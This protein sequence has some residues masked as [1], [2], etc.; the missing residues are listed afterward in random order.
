VGG[1]NLDRAMEV[2]PLFLEPEY[3]FEWGG[4]YHLPVGTYEL[5]CQEGPDPAMSVCVLPAPKGLH[6]AAEKAVLAFSDEPQDV[7]PGGTLTPGLTLHGLQFPYETQTFQITVNQPGEYALFTEHHPDEFAATLSGPDG[8]VESK[9][10]K[11]YKPDH[12]HDDEVSSVGIAMPGDLD[13]KK[14]NKWMS[15]LLQT[16]GQ[17]IFRMKGVLSIKGD[18][19]RFVFQGVHM[20]FDGKADRPW[21]KESRGNKLIFIG[22]NLDREGLLAGFKSC[23]V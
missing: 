6:D 8:A 1:F 5:T 23:L 11:A 14:L 16:Q 17:D 18:E 9:E 19:K 4:L 15:N 21:G 2:D 22:R 12:E 7:A 13:A 10:E 20:L 3:P